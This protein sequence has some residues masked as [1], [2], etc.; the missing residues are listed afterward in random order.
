MK[1]GDNDTLLDGLAQDLD[2]YFPKFMDLY[3]EEVFKFVYPKVG[4][5]ENSTWDVTAEVFLRVHRIMSGRTSKGIRKRATLPYL[6]SISRGAIKDFRKSLGHWQ[7]QKKINTI[8]VPLHGPTGL[9]HDIED[10]HVQQPEEELVQKENRSA[11]NQAFFDIVNKLPESNK[12]EKDIL[13]YRFFHE[14]SYDEIKRKFD[15]LEKIARKREKIGLQLLRETLMG[16]TSK[17]RR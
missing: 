13:I 4:K 7:G 8:Q 2:G 5:N 10:P 16:K 14:L 1:N 6:R 9:I 15:I 11:S 17:E 12:L 3:Q